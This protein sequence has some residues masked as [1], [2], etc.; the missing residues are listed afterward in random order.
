M[1]LGVQILSNILLSRLNPY[2][3][4]IIGVDLLTLVRLPFY[5]FFYLKMEVIRS[6]KRRLTQ[7][8]QG[9]TSQKTALF[10]VTAVKTSN[11]T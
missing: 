2:I 7:Y 5:S 9:A 6:P 8:I 11:L 1:L 3:D 4:G 10:I